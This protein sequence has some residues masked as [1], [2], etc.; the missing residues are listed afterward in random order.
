MNQ[1]RSASVLTWSLLKISLLTQLAGAIG[2]AI[3]AIR[4]LF[5]PSRA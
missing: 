5:G 3:P 2:E 1:G 4:R